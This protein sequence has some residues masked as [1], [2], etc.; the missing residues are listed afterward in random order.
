[1][2]N[3]RGQ[4]YLV[5]GIIILAILIGFFSISN[6]LKKNPSPYDVTEELSFESSKVLEYGETQFYDKP[7]MSLLLE[8]FTA[9]YSEY[10]GEDTRGYFVFGDENG[11]SAYTYEESSKGVVQLSLPGYSSS[12]IQIQGLE[13]KEIED[14]TLD[15]ENN[16][17]V[18]EIENIKYKFDLKPGENFY[19]ILSRKIGEEVYTTQR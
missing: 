13:K 6:S 5:A 11:I 8:H 12:S 4:F 2:K 1:M 19:F 10:A 18:V 15:T 3:K 14:I 7:Q 17:V 16:L 9:L